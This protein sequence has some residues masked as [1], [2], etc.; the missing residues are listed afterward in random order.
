MFANVFNYQFVKIN[1]DQN[2]ASLGAAAIAAVGSGFWEG[3][4]KIEEII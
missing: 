3:Y 2:A 1:T 4:E